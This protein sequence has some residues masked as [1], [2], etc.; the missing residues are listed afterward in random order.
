MDGWNTSFPLGWP[1]F[2]GYV[3]FREG[4]KCL[5]PSKEDFFVKIISP[6][7]YL[8]D[9]AFISPLH[10]P[11]YL[12]PWPPVFESVRSADFHFQLHSYYIQI[13]TKPISSTVTGKT[14]VFLRGKPTVAYTPSSL[15]LLI[16]LTFVFF[17]PS[18]VHINSYGRVVFYISCPCTCRTPWNGTNM[19][20]IVSNSFNPP[21]RKLSASQVGSS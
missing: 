3:S 10:S 5:K 8:P 9:M 2:R 7:W 11:S 1:I 20:Y 12:F 21:N 13:I 18:P 16:E 6:G 17:E 4:K 14:H 19:R 15:P